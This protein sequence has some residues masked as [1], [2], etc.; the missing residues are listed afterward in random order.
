MVDD[1]LRF[2]WITFRSCRTSF[3]RS[4][5]SSH[6]S[7]MSCIGL[8]CFCSVLAV[9]RPQVLLCHV[10]SLL[11]PADVLEVYRVAR[12]RRFLVQEQGFLDLRVVH[13]IL[14]AFSRCWRKPQI[15]R[16]ASPYCGMPRIPLRCSSR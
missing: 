15:P 9:F 3:S 4:L 2:L 8:G 11:F 6:S 1:I 16:L 12:L 14:H 7:M 13:V 10:I 5:N